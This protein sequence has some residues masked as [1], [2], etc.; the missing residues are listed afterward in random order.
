MCAWEGRKDGGR[1]GRENGCL[2]DPAKVGR[3]RKL[4][5]RW[6]LP[7]LRISFRA[8]PLGSADGRWEPRRTRAGLCVRG[9]GQQPEQACNLG[10]SMC[11]RLFLDIISFDL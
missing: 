2:D 8:Q 5:S 6:Q 7:S 4:T 11:A 9:K 10:C 3:V 1:E